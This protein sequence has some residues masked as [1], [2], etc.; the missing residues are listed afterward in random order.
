MSLGRLPL[1]GAPDLSGVEAVIER[2]S[3]LIDVEVSRI[4]LASTPQDAMRACR[5]ADA[6]V[7]ENRTVLGLLGLEEALD[8]AGATLIRVGPDRAPLSAIILA[9]EASRETIAA[10][11]SQPAPALLD[12]GLDALRPAARLKA[13]ADRDERD[14]QLQRAADQLQGVAGV[15][16][17]RLE[18]EGL[19]IE[20]DRAGLDRLENQFG[21][22]GRTKEG[23]LWLDVAD[24]ATARRLVDWLGVEEK[25]RTAT[26]RR[27]TKE[28]DIAL[29]V[30]LDGE[31]V[32]ADT[33][34]HFFDHML[35]QI[36]RHGGIG[37]NVVCE[38]DVEVDAHHTIEDVCLALGEALREALGDKRGIARFGFETPMDETRASV[39]IDLS[40]RPY[41]RFDGEIP[42]ERVGDFPIEMCAHAF[43]SLAESLRA[44]IHVKVDGENAHH[45]V[46]SCFKSFGRALRMAKTIEGDA[47]PS[48]KGV[49]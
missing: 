10:A 7:V 13:R 39:W 9:D 25:A 38:G 2:L 1:S 8:P 29:T 12:A 23:A 31:G 24:A 37:L 27:T 47:L 4:I 36:G 49:L 21:L 44:A 26:I 32:S 40:G 41:A 6:V 42:G 5:T 19:A 30:D 22:Q 16:R 14:G 45:M 20:A 15:Q 35:D 34:V 3:R 18:P 33:G 28:T 17:V 48:T 43:R 46:E 11:L